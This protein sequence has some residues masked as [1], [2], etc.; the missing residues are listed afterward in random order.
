MGNDT[1]VFVAIKHTHSAF[2]TGYVYGSSESV[3]ELLTSGRFWVLNV[4]HCSQW[5]ADGDR[6]PA[7]TIT[8]SPAEIAEWR[9]AIVDPA[10]ACQQAIAWAQAG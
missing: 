6:Y 2:L 3:R 5:Y 10:E 1:A 9:I 4:H 8:L 7:G